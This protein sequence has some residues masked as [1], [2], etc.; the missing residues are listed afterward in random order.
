VNFE[1]HEEKARS[2]LAKHGVSFTEAT[3]VFGDELSA[4]VPD[5]DRSESEQRFLVFGQTLGGRHVVVAFAERSGR[6]RLISAR[7]MTRRE[8]KAYEQ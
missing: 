8:R 3:E 6:I 2:N 4:T 5:P 1:W 7:A